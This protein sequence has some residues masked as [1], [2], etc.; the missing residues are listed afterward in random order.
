M[1]YIPMSQKDLNKYDV[2]KR[3]VRKEITIRKAGELLNLCSRQICRLKAAVKVKGAEGLIH[4]NRGKPSNRKI[5]DIERQQLANLLHRH[6]SDFKPTHAS[7]KLDE[8]HGI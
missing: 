6:Y 7:E 4:G 1:N 8:V 2:V 3:A 5:P